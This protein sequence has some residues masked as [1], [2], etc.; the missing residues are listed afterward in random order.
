MAK[1]QIR[2][3]TSSNWATANPVLS[4][5]EL[6]YVTDTNTLKI[7]DG[8]NNYANICV[9]A[10]SNPIDLTD[11]SV[12]TNSASGSGALTYDNTTGQFSFTPADLTS[13]D[14]SSKIG[15]TD[16]QVCCTSPSG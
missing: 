4:E 8:T 12:C 9:I 6:A 11:V 7:G 15:Y 3:D 16:L 5:G 1:I 10:K 13:I 14:I 2:R